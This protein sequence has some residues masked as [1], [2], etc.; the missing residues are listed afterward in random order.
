M[1]VRGHAIEAIFRAIR[2]ATKC[3]FVRKFAYSPYQEADLNT[4]VAKT[5]TRA[6]IES[7]KR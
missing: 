4:Q 6:T 2:V 5:K 1:F 7:I 3:K